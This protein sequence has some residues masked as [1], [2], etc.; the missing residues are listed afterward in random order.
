[1]RVKEVLISKVICQDESEPA[2]KL[3]M[4]A[5]KA[6]TMSDTHSS[7]TGVGLQLRRLRAT[8]SDSAH[9]WISLQRR[10]GLVGSHS[11]EPDINFLYLPKRRYFCVAEQKKLF[12]WV[13]L[14][15]Y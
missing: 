6:G 4:F 9:I 15:L 13:S 5:P 3:Q 12:L 2:S 8:V 11:Q 7:Q 1:M 14:K 10:E